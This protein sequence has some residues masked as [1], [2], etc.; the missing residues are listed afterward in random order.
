MRNILYPAGKAAYVATYN[1]PRNRLM[2]AQQ[3]DQNHVEVI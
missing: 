2:E 3:N 1:G